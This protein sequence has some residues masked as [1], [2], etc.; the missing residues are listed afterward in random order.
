MTSLG[1]PVPDPRLGRALRQPRVEEHRA[2][3]SPQNRTETS[4]ASDPRLPSC[5]PFDQALFLA[6]DTCSVGRTGRRPQRQSHGSRPFEPTAPAVSRHALRVTSP[7]SEP[8]SRPGCTLAREVT[9]VHG[10]P[11]GEVGVSEPRGA[12][13]PLPPGRAALRAALT[14]SSACCFPS[15]RRRSSRCFPSSRSRPT[16]AAAAWKIP[17]AEARRELDALA[18]RA[19]LLDVGE[20]R[21]ANLHPA[22]ADGRFL[23]VLDDA[24]AGRHRPAPAGRALLP[25][26][27]R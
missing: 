21:A 16:D 14:R 20:P 8:F 25:V 1:R 26:S 24:G 5:S 18:D 11:H 10:A 19:L 15:G 27:E 9:A 3:G 7:N 4:V 17:E 12:V 22:A 23:R 2:C 13:E 6:S